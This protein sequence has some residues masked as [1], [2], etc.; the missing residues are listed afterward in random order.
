MP[1]PRD[2]VITGMGVVC[3]LGV[4]CAA[5]WEALE[6][7]RSGIDWLP[8][9][10]GTESP[11]RFAARLKDFDAKQFVQPRKTIKVMCLEIQ[12]AYAAAALAMQDAGLAKGASRA[13]WP[14]ARRQ[15]PSSAVTPTRS[16]PAAAVRSPRSVACHFVAGA[17]YRNGKASH[18]AHRGRSM[19]G[20]V[21]S[22]Q[23]KALVCSSWKLAN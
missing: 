10:R 19:R 5:F 22:C 18:P 6:A 7:G 12:A 3:P 9:M 16:W 21:A 8:E 20:A 23:V 2:V 13:C 15:P 1:Q 4:G 17:I 14:L 11:F